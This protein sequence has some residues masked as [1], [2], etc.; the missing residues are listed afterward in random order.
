MAS[1]VIGKAEEEKMTDLLSALEDSKTVN[2]VYHAD[3]PNVGMGLTKN[4]DQFKVYAADTGLF[5][6]L[7]FWDKSFTENSIYQKLLSDKLSANLGFVYENMIA[8]MLAAAGNA[9]FY[10]T[11]PKDEKH[12]YEIDFLLSR[13]TKLCPIEVKSSGYNTHASLNAFCEKFASR[14]G[15]RYLLYTKDLNKDGPVTLTP[16]FL[17]P[18]I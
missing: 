2:L 6:T 18:M 15:E 14:I 17:T 8:Q 11:W 4:M 5:V 3:D 13:G 1:S 10:Y 16:A 12:Y 7:A 9:L